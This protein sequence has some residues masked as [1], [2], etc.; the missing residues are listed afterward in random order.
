MDRL[1]KKY[2]TSL[3][4]NTA[5]QFKASLPVLKACAIIDTLATPSATSLGIKENGDDDIKGLAKQFLSEN[6]VEDNDD[7]YVNAEKLKA[8]WG[9]FK[10]D[11]TEWKVDIPRELKDGKS[12]A[13]STTWTIHC[14]TSQSSFPHFFPLLFFLAQC[15]LSI[16]VSKTWPQRGASVLKHKKTGL[17]NRL[18]NDKQF[19]AWR[20]PWE[21]WFGSVTMVTTVPLRRLLISCVATLQHLSLILQFHA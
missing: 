9:K 11:L 3:I 18:K 17:H 13:T 21:V 1:R 15:C 8:Q 10:C 20:K 16:S 5:N 6:E 2:V 14:M 19:L 12:A 4:T 7:T